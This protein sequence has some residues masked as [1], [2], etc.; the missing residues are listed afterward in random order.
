MRVDGVDEARVPVSDGIV[1]GDP[2]LQMGTAL[3]KPAELEQG[4]PDEAMPHHLR[5][6][7]ALFL[8]QAC[9]SPAV[10]SSVAWT[11]RDLPIPASPTR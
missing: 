5:G 2:R 7:V 11:S 4:G 8:G 9:S 6:G 10:A 1:E 3:G